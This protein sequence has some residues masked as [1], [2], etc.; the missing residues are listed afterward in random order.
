MRV[1]HKESIP[2]LCDVCS[3]G[4]V[5][6]QAIGR[7][8]NFFNS[9]AYGLPT[10]L[11]WKLYISPE[12]RQ[13]PFQNYEYFH[14][15]FLYESI[16]D[17]LLFLFIYYIVKN[18]YQRR[19]GNVFLI[20]LILYSLIRIFVETYR[21]DSITYIMGVPVA[22]VFSLCIIILAVFLLLKRNLNGFCRK[23]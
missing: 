18:N 17:F 6:S 23:K 19:D 7:W 10:N 9:E 20:Y 15:T 5:L 14:P 1:L 2:K 3:V 12:Y 4:L 11:P 22:I 8:G 21:I 16:L 13:I